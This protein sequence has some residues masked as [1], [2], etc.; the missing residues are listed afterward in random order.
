[1]KNKEDYTPYCKVC[2]GC[3]EDGCCSAM[4]C[5]FSID[6]K[7]CETYLNDLKFGFLMYKDIYDFGQLVNMVSMFN[8]REKNDIEST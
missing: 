3:G 2:T 5:N 6:C 7:Y 1:M 4:N 8:E